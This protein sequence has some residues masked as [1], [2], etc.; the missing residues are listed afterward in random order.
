MEIS[1]AKYYN[2]KYKIICITC[3]IDGKNSAVPLDPKNRH[4]AE[5]QKQVK[6]GKLTIKDAD[7]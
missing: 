1:N 6:E 7:E 3:T 2:D 4:Y 5:I